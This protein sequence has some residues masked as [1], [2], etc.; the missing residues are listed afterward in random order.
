MNTALNSRDFFQATLHQPRGV[1]QPD[2]LRPRQHSDIH[3]LAA[4]LAA[5]LRIG[6]GSVSAQNPFNAVRWN[7]PVTSLTAP[8]FGMVTGTAPGRRV[9][10][11]LEFLW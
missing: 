10:L 2:D 6:F 1:F 11:Y 5:S 3:G 4:G 8:S 7:N 9:Q